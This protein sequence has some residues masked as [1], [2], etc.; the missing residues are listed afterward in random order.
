MTNTPE[1]TGVLVAL[2][3]R[4]EQQRPPRETTLNADVDRGEQETM[5]KALAGEQAAPVEKP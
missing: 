1:D 4:F 2:I 3:E 5:D